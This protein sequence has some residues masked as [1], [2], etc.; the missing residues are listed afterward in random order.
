MGNH[1][2][3][4]TADVNINY[5]QFILSK[6][7]EKV[8]QKIQSRANRHLLRQLHSLHLLH[9]LCARLEPPQIGAINGF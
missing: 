5:N 8:D 2:K 3:K 1:R 9:K 4:I 6:K 7:L